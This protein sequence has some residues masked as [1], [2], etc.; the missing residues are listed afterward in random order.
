MKITALEGQK[1]EE[2]SMIEVAH[3]ILEQNG[4]E[5]TFAEI[6]N[7]VQD[8]L[9]KSDDEIK[10]TIGRFYT[11]MNTDGSFIP[12]GNNVWALRSWYAIDEIDEEVIAL[13]ELDDEDEAPIKKRSKVNAFGIED[14]I[15]P[16]DEATP[17]PED[18]VIY[19]DENPDDEKDEVEAYDA[20]LKEVE[21]DNV[22]DDVDIDVDDD[23]DDDDREDDED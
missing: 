16:E 8:Y 18:E 11:E 9:Q 20:E 13:D 21:L 5:L 6:L 12:L 1:I 22:E 14:E 15:D 10:A 2:L 19:D 7:A 17:T 23:D 3:A 4:K